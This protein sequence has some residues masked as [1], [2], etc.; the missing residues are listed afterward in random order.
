[1]G[2]DGFEQRIVE[3]LDGEITSEEEN[4]LKD[5][6]QICDNCREFYKDIKIYFELFISLPLLSPE[7]DFTNKVMNQIQSQ[8]RLRDLL[9]AAF[10]LAIFSISSLVQFPKNLASLMNGTEEMVDFMGKLFWSFGSLLNT[11]IALV[12]LIGK[13]FY[14]SEK[15][16]I[17]LAQSVPIIPAGIIGAL[18]FAHIYL[19][20]RWLIAK[21]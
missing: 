14:K 3:Y 16:L 7:R 1:M 20:S 10:F 8:R 4:T 17:L 5:H 13:I 21:T 2:C 18:I 11:T 19:L 15:I 6:L 9:A 12:N